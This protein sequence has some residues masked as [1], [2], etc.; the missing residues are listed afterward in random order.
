MKR[1]LLSAVPCLLVMGGC[2][3][4]GDTGGGS[5]DQALLEEYLRAIPS[6]SVLGAPVPEAGTL[7]KGV[8]EVGEPAMFPQQAVPVAKN[9]NQTIKDMLDT[10]DKVV[11]HPPTVYNSETKEF[12]WGPIDNGSSAL[13][14]DSVALYIRDQGEDADFRYSYAW[15][16]GVGSDA[17]TLTPVIWGGSNPDPDN[18]DYGDGVALWDY[19]AN[20]QWLL[21][22]YPDQAENVTRGRFVARYA[23]GP[24]SAEPGDI[25]TVVVAVFRDYV[26]EGADA[27][28]IPEDLDYFWG[29][30]F[31]GTNELD[32]LDFAY[33][34]DLKGTSGE[35]PEDI[36][37]QLAFYNNGLGRA[38]AVATG[39][40][41]PED[42]P[43]YYLAADECWD[44]A[45]LR[46]FYEVLAVPEEGSTGTSPYVVETEGNADDCVLDSLETIPS[47][48]DLDPAF[49]A[50]LD[51]LASNGV[52]V[53]E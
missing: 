5:Y 1:L 26:A 18:E 19:E 16:R 27:D 12:F 41:L 20:Y 43:G 7:Q 6:A 33:Q 15:L 29:N 3:T 21:E 44:A 13:E 42:M 10:L 30:I 32:F 14:G 35:T 36:D 51:E 9:I 53:S 22:Y 17:S 39:G 31:D 45:L 4:G 24:S 49:L 2:Q 46:T 50:A 37:L 8:A 40:D 28:A 25:V 38:E 23:K 11:Q 34:D 48:D 52:P 47:L